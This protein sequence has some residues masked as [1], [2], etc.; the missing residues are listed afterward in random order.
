MSAIV[1]TPMGKRIFTNDITAS[2]P[3]RHEDIEA[4]VIEE[5]VHRLPPK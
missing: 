3:L 4:A 5:A 1:S 2:S